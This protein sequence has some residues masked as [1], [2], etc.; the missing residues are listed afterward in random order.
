MRLLKD[1]QQR[2]AYDWE[3]VVS[4][5]AIGFP[6]FNTIRECARWARPIWLAE[7]SRYG[8]AGVPMPSIKGLP[9]SPTNRRVA[10]ATTSLD[11]REIQLSKPLRNRY[12]ILHEMA[13]ALIA[14]HGVAH[15]S[16]GPEWLGCYIGLLCRHAGFSGSLLL[17]KARLHG[18]RY[19]SPMVGKSPECIPPAEL[20][21][22][23]MFN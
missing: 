11:G 20:L 16:H 17:R 3:R 4:C 8:L 6:E 12:G 19:S 7:R 23:F 21:A 5:E 22:H 1:R 15:E 14:T 2:A 9:R 18:L 10:G 13:H